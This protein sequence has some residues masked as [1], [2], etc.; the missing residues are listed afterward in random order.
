MGGARRGNPGRVSLAPRMLRD[1]GN[2]PPAQLS[3][4]DRGVARKRR[5]HVMLA[6]FGLLL[7]VAAADVGL[8]LA[9]RLWTEYAK[10]E[11]CP[12]PAPQVAPPPAAVVAERRKYDHVRLL[13]VRYD[14]VEV[15]V[16]GEPH[17]LPA[18]LPGLYDD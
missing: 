12:A 10:Q 14:R 16:E 1:D 13:A 11:E 17:V 9:S 18:W 5:T 6:V 8:Q 3:G 2:M 4:L 15:E 7:T